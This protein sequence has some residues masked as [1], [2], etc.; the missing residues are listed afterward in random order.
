MPSRGLL[1]LK[2]AE[3]LARSI[4]TKACELKGLQASAETLAPTTMRN[5]VTGSLGH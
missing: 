3:T 5:T 4:N 1:Q 2:H